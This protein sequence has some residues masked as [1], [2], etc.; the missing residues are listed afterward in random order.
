[1][2][3]HSRGVAAVEFVITAPLLVFVMLATAE[4][5][6]AFVHYDTLSYSLR[7]SA[8]FL[9]ENALTGT[10]GVVGLSDTVVQQARNLAVF[11]NVV[12][13]GQRVLPNFQTTQITV[14]G[15]GGHVQVA[16][17][18]PYQPM[19]GSVLPTFGVAA[20]SIPLGFDMS[21]VVT[22]RAVS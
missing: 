15:G 13:T 18:Y 3:H 2:P 6:R 12:G 22:M 14:T 21:I 10:S 17:T 20:G 19:I 8:R 9:T 16:A 4:V 11:G 5:G 7:N 1:M